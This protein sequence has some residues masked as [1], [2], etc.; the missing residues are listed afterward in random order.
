V[1][2]VKITQ[3]GFCTARSRSA[4]FEFRDDDHNESVSNP[5]ITL[6]NSGPLT[7]FSDHRRLATCSQRVNLPEMPQ[8][9][10]VITREAACQAPTLPPPP[11]SKALLRNMAQDEAF[12]EWHEC[13]MKAPCRPEPTHKTAVFRHSSPL[14]TLRIP[15]TTIVQYCT[16]VT[17]CITC[18]LLTGHAFTG[19][20]TTRFRPRL[21][22]PHHCQCREPFQTVHHVIATY[23]PHTKPR[24]QFLLPVSNTLSISD[25][26]GMN[27]GGSVLGHFLVT[28][29]SLHKAHTPCYA[30]TSRSG[31]Y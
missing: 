8:S 3:G 18:R 21:F 29:S 2:T 11:S 19:E 20:Y 28:S 26:S 14:W 30:R 17:T 4:L 15:A 16:V 13:W 24:T 9:H 10:K 25:I 31:C 23:M 5:S 27:K 6:R 22:D 1:P 12:V 7:P